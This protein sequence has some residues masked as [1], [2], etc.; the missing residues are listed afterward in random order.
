MPVPKKESR[1]EY[2]QRLYATPGLVLPEK[3][4]ENQEIEKIYETP[5]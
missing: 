5:S 2:L 1:E 3:N 4:I